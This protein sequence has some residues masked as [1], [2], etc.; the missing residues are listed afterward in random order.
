MLSSSRLG[1]KSVHHRAIDVIWHHAFFQL[2]DAML[3]YPPLLNSWLPA[4]VV[5]G[6][7][8]L[9]IAL[10]GQK[11]LAVHQAMPIID[12][13]NVFHWGRRWPLLWVSGN[14]LRQ[15]MTPC[16]WIECISSLFF[17]MLLAP[18]VAFYNTN[19][20]LSYLIST[21][22][23]KNNSSL[24]T[25]I[26]PSKPQHLLPGIRQCGGALRQLLLSHLRAEAP[27]RRLEESPALH[28]FA[29]QL[30]LLGRTGTCLCKEGVLVFS[31]LSAARSLSRVNTEKQQ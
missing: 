9:H 12:E 13:F 30:V 26:H 15:G 14:H 11:P 16:L 23:L 2:P 17:N 25:T 5:R 28:P 10:L 24:T 19:I 1:I 8:W 22:C 7:V 21:Q 31:T 29:L 3:S 18:F 4:I 6:A 20:T 27:L